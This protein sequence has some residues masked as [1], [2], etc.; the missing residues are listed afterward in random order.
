MGDPL[1]IG[2]EIIARALPKLKRFCR[3]LVI[4]DAAV[5]TRALRLVN[6]RLKINAPNGLLLHEPR[7]DGWEKEARGESAR[8]ACLAMASVRTGVLACTRGM[9]DALVT[10]PINKAH[11]AQAGYPYPGHTDYLAFLTSCHQ[12]AMMLTGGELRVALVTTHLPLAAVAAALSRELIGRILTITTRG[13]RDFFGAKKPRLAVLGLNPH[14]GD[15]GALGKEEIE[16]ISPAIKDA[17]RR[18]IDAQGPFPADAFFRRYG[19]QLSPRAALKPRRAAFDA[20]LAMYHD[21]GL[22]AVKMLGGANGVNV[23]LGLPIV[24]TSPDHGTADDIAW[25]G[26]GDATSLLTAAEMAVDIARRRR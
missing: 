5:M 23:T 14:A 13:L 8:A 10:A 24:R 15:R 6:S 26:K 12:Y 9:A 22:V 16:I 21:Q 18:G 7:F 2:P 19:R 1:G 25:K 11:L 4:G 3:P 17:R 20:V